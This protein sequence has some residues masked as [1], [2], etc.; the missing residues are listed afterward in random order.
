VSPAA[1]TKAARSPRTG[2]AKNAPKDEPEATGEGNGEVAEE[3]ARE[4]AR[5]E[6]EEKAAAEREAMIEAGDLI[7]T[8]DFEFTISEKQTASAETMA[9][10]INEYREAD[11]P[12]VFND[13]ATKAGAKYPEDLVIAMYALEELD[14]VRK[15]TAKPAGADAAG[16]SKVAFLWVDD[17]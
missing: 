8:K 12:L 10:I 9:K 13:V 14:F 5:R 6:K 11:E 3:S 16:R 17:E 1:K 7:V 4:A 15:F 2:K